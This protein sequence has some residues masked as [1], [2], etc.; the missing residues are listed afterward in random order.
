MFKF[1][2]IAIAIISFLLLT[3]VS[4]PAQAQIENIKDLNLNFK[5]SLTGKTNSLRAYADGHYMIIVFFSTEC[6]ICNMQLPSVER[7]HLAI[8]STVKPEKEKLP[9]TRI[10]SIAFDTWAEKSVQPFMQE[11]KYSFDVWFDPMARKSNRP[12]KIDKD[13]IPAI[14]IYRPDGTLLKKGVGFI[15]DLDTLSLKLIVEDSK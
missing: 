11:N 12:F 14:Y 5:S 13:G 10:V 9:P 15:R 7:L 3:I 1:T 6:P 2:T 4:M 8:N